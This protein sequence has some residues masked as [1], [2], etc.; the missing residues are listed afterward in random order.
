MATCVPWWVC[1]ILWQHVNILTPSNKLYSYAPHLVGGVL[2]HQWLFHT[3]HRM[4]AL[5]IKGR[6]MLIFLITF[7]TLMCRD[8]TCHWQTSKTAAFPPPTDL[9]IFFSI[10]ES[11]RL[12]V[13]TFICRPVTCAMTYPTSMNLGGL[14]SCL[15]WMLRRGSVPLIGFD[16]ASVWCI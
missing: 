5:L 7:G 3:V 15:P 8:L 9:S 13:S 6:D 16:L 2:H 11:N 14:P 1:I 10:G 4:N 12:F